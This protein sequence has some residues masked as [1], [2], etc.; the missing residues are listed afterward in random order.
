MWRS[1]E[2]LLLTLLA[3]ALHA[4]PGWTWTSLAPLPRP[5]ANHAFCTATVNGD[6]RAYAF[7]GITTG[8]TSDS[9]TLRA[10]QYESSIDAWR[11]LPDVPDTLGRVA[12]AASVVNGVA[13]VIGGYHVFDGPPFELSSDRVHRFDLAS[14]VWLPDGAPVPVPI[15]DQVQAVWRDSLIYVVT[16]WSDGTNVPDVQV[17]DPA[18]DAWQSATPVPNNNLYKVFGASG[19]IVGDTIYYYGGASLG[20]NFPAQ[21]E[22]RMGIIDPADPLQVTWLPPVPTGRTVYR[23]GCF[24]LAGRPHWLGGSSVS[25]NYDGLAYAG[26]AVVPPLAEVAVY[27]PGGGWLGVE[28]TP[29]A[30]MDLRGMGGWPGGEVMLAGGIGPDTTVLASAWRIDPLPLGVPAASESQ[31]IIQVFPNPARDRI[32]VLLPTGSEGGALELFS[33]VGQRLEVV[34]VEDVTVQIDLSGHPAGTYVLQLSAG[35]SVSRVR[36]WSVD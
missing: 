16:G 11:V 5:M 19:T 15:D 17:Y 7:M 10:Y 14:G 32:T 18:N 35:S 3:G 9:I 20:F 31:P 6:E 24:T 29:E 30:V 34:D 23:P 25:Y 13:Y 2:L 4:Q 33:A 26:G 22:L 1:A 36:F 12:S 8:L 21:D 28:T 27:D